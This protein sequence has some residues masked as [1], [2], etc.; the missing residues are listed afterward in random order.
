M[1]GILFD[2]RWLSTGIGTYTLNLIK[3]LHTRSEIQLRLVTL[4]QH[5]ATLKT[6]CQDVEVVDAPMYSIKEQFA[7]GRAAHESSVLHVPHYNAPVMYQ[8]SLLVTILDLTHILDRTFKKTVKSKLYARPILN[9]V[10]RKA[11]HIFTLSQYSKRTIVE[12]LGVPDDKVT[13]TYCGVASHFY[14]EDRQKALA[15]MQHE[16]DIKGS[17]VLFV[18][19]L[20]SHKN[21]SG[22]LRAFAKL[23]KRPD[24][25]GDLVIIGEDAKG[26]SVLKALAFELGVYD[27]T[28]F[29]ARVTDEVLRCAYSAAHLTVLPSFEEGFGLPVIESMACGTPVACSNAAALPEV[30]G[31]AATYFD[32]TDTDSMALAIRQLLESVE[33]RKEHQRLGFENIKRF[34]WSSCAEKH[35]DVYRRYITPRSTN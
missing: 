21:V 30:G 10:S 34:T 33:Q 15:V 5:A 20:K 6:Y 16:C 12:H 2:A 4:P 23:T 27:R 22:L 35:L 13:V 8:G 28:K 25:N 1:G 24:Y 26:A 18:G 9:V 3:E 17:Y 19:N 32:P 7:L 29:I 11:K 31:A 14:P